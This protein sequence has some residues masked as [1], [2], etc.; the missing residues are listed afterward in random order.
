MLIVIANRP[1]HDYYTLY[2][3]L[4]WYHSYSPLCR[5]LFKNSN[6]VACPEGLKFGVACSG[7]LGTPGVEFCLKIVMESRVRR[8]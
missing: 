7:R 1:S 5:I 6:G 3:L 4:T 8:A 2:M